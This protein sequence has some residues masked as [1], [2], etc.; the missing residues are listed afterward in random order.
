MRVD[1]RGMQKHR[2]LKTKK[3]AKLKVK[4]RD[5]VD[6]RRQKKEPDHGTLKNEKLY[7]C[8]K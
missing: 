7:D 8:M 4:T 1:A 5:K 3:E 6:K 2:R